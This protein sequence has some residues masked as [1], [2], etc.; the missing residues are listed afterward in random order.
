MEQTH[1][2]APRKPRAKSDVVMKLVLR[3]FRKHI[4]TQYQE[5][6]GRRYYYWVT[7]SIKRKT[8]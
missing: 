2:E 5:M 1:L 7:I 6:F 4:K 8:R 3:R